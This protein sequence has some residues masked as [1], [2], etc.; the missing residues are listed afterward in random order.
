MDNRNELQCRWYGSSFR[1]RVAAHEPS[2]LVDRRRLEAAGPKN[3]LVERNS[4]P[5]LLR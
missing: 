2:D 3:G 5:G 1:P 4:R